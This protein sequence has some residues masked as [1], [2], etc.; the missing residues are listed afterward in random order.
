MAAGVPPFQEIRFIR[1]EDTTAPVTAARA[2]RQGG[3]A[4][5]AKDRTLADAQMGRHRMTWPPAVSPCPHLL[6]ECHALRPT[7]GDL[8]QRGRGGE[9][10]G[11]SDRHG[12]VSQGHTLTPL[13]VLDGVERRPMRVE[14]V[15]KGFHQILKQVKPISNLGGLGCPVASTVRI[16]CG[17]VAR[18]D[19]H[20]RVGPQPLR[21]RLGLTIGQCATGCRR[22]RSI[23]T[24]P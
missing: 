9:R 5:I 14:H 11:D 7:L 8:L 1:I 24:V 6:M 19:F 22:A 10:W 3:A 17:S 18:D 20:P 16:G 2:L 23:S 12:V 21:Q 15:F 13:P 4:E